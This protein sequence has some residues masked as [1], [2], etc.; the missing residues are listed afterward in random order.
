[1]ACTSFKGLR[2]ESERFLFL[3]DCGCSIELGG[4]VTGEEM[5]GIVM[6]GGEEGKS[7]PSVEDPVGK[8]LV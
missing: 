2:S 6:L 3:G 1:L 5:S 4:Y 7:P 8:R